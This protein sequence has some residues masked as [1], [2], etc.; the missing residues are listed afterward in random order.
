MEIFASFMDADV[1]KVEMML[2]ELD[3]KFVFGDGWRQTF[4]IENSL[5]DIS[6]EQ[7]I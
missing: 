7:S 5:P 6:T 4:T 1:D 3:S 2:S